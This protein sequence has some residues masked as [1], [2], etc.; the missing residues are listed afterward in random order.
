M[1]IVSYDNEIIGV[2]D[3][4]DSA[5]DAIGR[6]YRKN[7]AYHLSLS[8]EGNIGYLKGY[9]NNPQDLVETFKIVELKE[10]F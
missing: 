8:I 6:Y 10:N 3:D 4:H 5:I 9:S 7:I 2:Y 1:F